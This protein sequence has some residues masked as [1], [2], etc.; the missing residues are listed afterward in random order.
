MKRNNQKFFT[1]KQVT[2]LSGV[3]IHTLKFW[4]KE[5]K[6]KLKENSAG[7]KIFTQEDIDQILMIKHLRYDEKLTIVGIKRKL[8]ELKNNNKSN[9]TDITKKSIMLI[10]KELIAIKNLLQQSIGNE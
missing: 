1:L 2:K 7:R 6:M 9:K 4:R 3:P 10:Q 5:F 8:R